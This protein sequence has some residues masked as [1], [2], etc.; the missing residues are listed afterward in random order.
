MSKQAC[1]RRA[2][3]DGMRPDIYAGTELGYDSYRMAEAD[4]YIHW[5]YTRFCT[6]AVGVT[7]A[8]AEPVTVGES[9]GSAVA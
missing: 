9:R 7:C 6:I 5:C 8:C 1:A 2:P 4:R 3:A